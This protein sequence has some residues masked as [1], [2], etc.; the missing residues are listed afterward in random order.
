MAVGVLLIPSFAS[1]ATAS[2]SSQAP[3]TDTST[4][5]IS[6]VRTDTTISAGTTVKVP[7]YITNL[8]SSPVL[9]Q[10]IENDFISGDE[11]GTP[12]ILLDANSYAPTHSLKRFMVALPNVLV[13]S[14]ATQKVDVTITIPKAAQAGGYFGAIRFAPTS[15]DG[16]KSVSIGTSVASLILVTVPGPYVEQMNLTNFDVQQ[17]GGTATNFRT[18]ND[19]SLLLRFQNK[20]NVQL[21]PFGQVYIQKGKKV[22]Y[23]YSFN[24]IEPKAQILPDSARRWTVPVKNLGKFGK[25]TIGATFGYGTKGQSIDVSKT[26][27]I[28]PTT[29]IYAGVGALVAI[30]VLIIVI[31]TFLKSYKKRILRASRRRY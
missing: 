27:W 12:A 19:L 10:P 26:I 28:V 21:A 11:H 7:V 29:Y 15:I 24:N 5:K 18:P 25:Y 14:N 23:S 9:L 13:A 3:V 31:V 2:K 1:A 8:K 20:G 30:I 22:V 17:N 4:L 16:S 6:P